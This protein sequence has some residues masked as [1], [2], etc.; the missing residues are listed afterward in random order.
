MSAPR[1]L[2]LL[3]LTRVAGAG[4]AL[5][6]DDSAGLTRALYESGDTTAIAAV[7]C[8]PR[9]EFKDYVGNVTLPA[10]MTKLK[11]FET[12]AFFLMTGKLT[13]NIDAPSLEI[14]K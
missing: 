2:L 10:G 6:P 14:I 5:C 1:V 8:I 7:T 11:S 3:L 12:L 4:A 9:Q 13:I